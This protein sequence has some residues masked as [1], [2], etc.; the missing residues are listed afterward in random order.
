MDFL[1]KKAVIVFV[2]LVFLSLLAATGV[3]GDEW[4]LKTQ[5]TV[6]QPFE[7]PG[8]VLQPNTRYVIRLMDTTDRHVVQVYN[9]DESKMLAMFMAVSDQRTEPTDHTLFTFIET[10]P[11]YALPIKEW[12]YPGHSTGLEFIY[13]KKQAEE[14]SRHSIESLAYS[15]TE[16]LHH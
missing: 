12:F 4:D 14:I 3:Y 11:G 16:R 6:S 8:A 10:Q 2:G 5:F 9:D 1:H 15:K 13:P 7:V